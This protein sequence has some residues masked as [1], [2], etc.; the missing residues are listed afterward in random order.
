[1]NVDIIW[2]AHTNKIFLF[3]LCG[4]HGGLKQQGQ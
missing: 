2:N 3:L 4:L 1:M